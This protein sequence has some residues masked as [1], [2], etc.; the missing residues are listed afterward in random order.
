MHNTKKELLLDLKLPTLT[1]LPTYVIKKHSRAKYVKLMVT[2]S[3][4]LKITIPIRFNIK[5][6]P[7]VLEEHKT[8]IV[9]Q[10]EKTEPVSIIDELPSEIKFHSLNESW[11]IFYIACNNKL[12][13]IERPLKEIVILGNINNKINNKKIY[14]LKL[15]NWI[16]NI[17]RDYLITQ[18]NKISKITQLPYQ[19]VSVRNQETMWG[20]CTSKKNISLNY[21]LVFLPEYLVNYVLIHELCHTVF[22]NHSK[23][24]WNLVAQFDPAW[25]AHRKELHLSHHLIPGWIQSNDEEDFNNT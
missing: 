1:W 23:K 12:K 3:R 9:K 5:N 10:I 6:L 11:K 22:L 16:K 7:K 17:A 13:I 24:F 25:Q 21:K 4:C 20:S 19:Q 18:L 8:W 2:H 14:K 15:I